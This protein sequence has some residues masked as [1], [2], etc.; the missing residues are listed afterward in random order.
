MSWERIRIR[1]FAIVGA[2]CVLVGAMVRCIEVEQAE[3]PLLVL[4][5]TLGAAMGLLIIFDVA[6]HSWKAEGQTC[7]TCGHVRQMK[8]FRFSGACPECGS[9]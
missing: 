7:R 5:A 8:S 3:M 6:Y 2:A 4:F 1:T 9:E